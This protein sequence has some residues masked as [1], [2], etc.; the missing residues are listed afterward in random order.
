MGVP[1]V[2]GKRSD[3]HCRPRRRLSGYVASEQETG[4]FPLVRGV[5]MCWMLS[6]PF[7]VH[8]FYVAG[9]AMIFFFFGH[10]KRHAGS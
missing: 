10:T 7:I 3:L 6:V 4:A 8:T 2:Q 5:M 1:T 9:A